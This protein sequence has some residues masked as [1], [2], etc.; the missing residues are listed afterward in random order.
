MGALLGVFGLRCVF[1]DRWFVLSIVCLTVY[2]RLSV[3][4]LCIVCCM[5]V[6][7]RM[8][9]VGHCLFVLRGALCVLRLCDVVLEVLGSLCM[10]LAFVCVVFSCG[11]S[12]RVTRGV[13]VGL[14]WGIWLCLSGLVCCSHLFYVI[15]VG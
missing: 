11:V 5:F 7:C 13:A 4:V 14:L 2:V 15:L 10:G 6:C 3:L 8:V 1:F 12:A 9:D